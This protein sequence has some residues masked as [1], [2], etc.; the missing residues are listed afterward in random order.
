M[1]QLSPGS[2]HYPRKYSK[3]LRKP[4]WM[5]G[6]GRRRV[7]ESQR[8]KRGRLTHLCYFGGWLFIWSRWPVVSLW[9][10][11][12]PTNPMFFRA[13]CARL[14]CLVGGVLL[15]HCHLCRVNSR[16][17]CFSGERVKPSAFST[18]LPTSSEAF[19]VLCF[20]ARCVE[21]IVCELFVCSWAL[22]VF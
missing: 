4:W 14:C 20:A 3:L 6:L 10:I 13:S 19:K 7:E 11:A 15:N 18:A 12:V 16:V 22:A 8:C 21:W 9:F 1:V 17:G 2:K 5:S